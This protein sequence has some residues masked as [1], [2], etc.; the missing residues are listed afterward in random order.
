MLSAAQAPAAPQ[1]LGERLA[2]LWTTYMAARTSDPDAA[3]VWL[4]EIARLLSDLPHDIVAFAIDETIRTT[5]HGF[6]PSVGEIRGIAD[7]LAHERDRQ[8]QRLAAIVAELEKPIVTEEPN[9][10]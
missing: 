9:H 10:D 1:W 2:V 8:V 3:T 5:R 4:V 6:I 7:P